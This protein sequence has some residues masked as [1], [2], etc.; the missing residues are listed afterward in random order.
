MPK[1]IKT[2]INVEGRVTEQ[3]AIVEEDELPVWGEGEELGIVGYPI[4]RVDG[5]ARVSGEARYTYD[6]RLPG[7]VYA[8]LLRATQPHAR[9]IGVETQRARAL[10]GVLAIMT[11][12]D[13]SA[14]QSSNRRRLLEDEV[15]FIGQPIA[16]VVADDPDHARDAAA[17]IAVHYEPLPFVADPEA[18]LQ[19]SAPPVRLD[20]PNNLHNGK[21]TV[22]ERGD[23]AAGLREADAIVELTVR[24]PTALH[25]PLET[26]G[27]V[28]HWE[29]DQLTIYESTQHAF[30]VRQFAARRLE[31]PLSRVRA[32]GTFMGGGFGAKFPG[33]AET[34]IAAELARRLRRPV[35]LMYDREGENLE[36]GNRSQTIQRIRLG[37]KRDGTLTAIEF[38]AICEGGA[39]MSWLPMVE[40]PAALQY[41]CP[42]FRSEVRGVY[43]NLGPFASFRAPGFVEGT[44]GLELAMDA[45]AER[46]GIDPL[47]LRR[48]NIPDRDQ[49]EDKPFSSFPIDEC[50]RRGAAAIGWERRA[51][52]RTQSGRYRRG[53]GM[54]S[55]IWWG[56][57][58]PPAY[59][60][61]LLNSDGTATIMTGTQDIGT[62]TRTI[63]AQVAAEEL[64][65]PLDQISV[66]IGD[67]LQGP[68]GPASGGSITTGSMAP[69]VR[70]AAHDLR[71]TICDVVAQMRDV[72]RDELEIREGT[73]YRRDERLMSVRELARTLGDVMLR[74]TGSRGPNPD[75]V[76]VVTS[77]AQFAEVEVDTVTG[78]VRVLRI[79]A[80]HDSGRII[81]PQTFNSQ[82]YGGIIQGLGYALTEERVVDPQRGAVL[83]PNLEWYK[84]PTIADVP[85]IDNLL[86]DIPDTKAN[87]TG[88]KGAGEPGIIPTAAAIANAVAHALGVRITEL[89]LTPARVLAALEAQTGSTPSTPAAEEAAR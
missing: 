63:L 49:M 80:A 87:S 89:P 42:N 36:T 33:R 29:G 2:T 7:M 61:A 8:H 30:G 18:A 14:A 50:Y 38:Q 71:R 1:V 78:R 52:L 24:T 11:C 21:P 35:H 81:N 74:G 46:L 55:Q 82:I 40:G 66:T 16:V 54:A 6:V 26:H 62:G 47:E 34:L 70:A 15:R 72:P 64:G 43:T 60:E 76:S 10:P 48:R 75:D 77:G 17:L 65:L 5:A 73:I 83:N 57:G 3:F 68:F 45:L 84:V 9:V 41:R 86:I 13:E 19:P 58:G 27:C 22:R 85:A 59:A 37:A 44:V 20:R 67:T 51:Q 79:V 32:I 39:S 88:A 56:G 28:A 31:L 53:L 69:A 23:I 25:N 4:P 12:L